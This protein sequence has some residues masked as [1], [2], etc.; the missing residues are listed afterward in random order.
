M[1]KCLIVLVCL[2]TCCGTQVFAGL[3]DGLVAYYPFEGNV[4]DHSSIGNSGIEHNISYPEGVLGKA[5]QFDGGTSYIEVPNSASL[6]P[7]SA[8]TVSAWVNTQHENH[9][10][11][12]VDKMGQ[13]SGPGWRMF[14]WNTPASGFLFSI[15]TEN[16][17]WQENTALNFSTGEWH[18]VLAVY[19]GNNSK[20]YVDGNLK[21][22]LTTTGLIINSDCN[23]FIGCRPDRKYFFDGLIDE[24]R[25][26]D[27]ALTESEVQELYWEGDFP[28]K[29]GLVAHYPFEGDAKDVSGN[30][31][32]GTPSGGVNYVE[33][34]KGQTAYF[35]GIDD[36][37]DLGSNV[38][39]GIRCIS[40]W[41][42]PQEIFDYTSLIT[43]NSFGE[44]GEFTL[45]FINGSVVWGRRVGS[46]PYWV[47]SDPGTWTDGWY[48]IVGNIS[49]ELGMQLYING[50][51]CPSQSQTSTE[52]TDSRSE[53]TSIGRWGDYD[54]RYFKG[55]IDE[56]RIYNRALSEAEIQELY[57][58][59]SEPD[60]NVD[61]VSYDF[62]E[63]E[64][65]SPSTMYVN[66][67]N[68]GGNTLTVND[69]Y[70]LYSISGEPF[71]AEIPSLP[72][73]IAA[74]TSVDIPVSYSPSFLFAAQSNDLIIESDD[75]DE[76]NIEV[77]FT[78]TGVVAAGDPPDAI[79]DILFYIDFAVN[80]GTLV[81]TGDGNSAQAHYEALK[82]ILTSA[83][84]ANNAC[85]PLQAAY[86]RVDGDPKQKD[87][88][89]GPAVE[90]IATAIE[91]VMNELG[92]K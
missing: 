48:H 49:E 20:I 73:K 63:V 1:R 12:I 91:N 26:Y 67:A 64:V 2:L 85:G 15:Y 5:A 78:G 21:E 43:R 92:C 39:N 74:N 83:G 46:I 89:E 76:P 86:K 23:L 57:L 58:I 50:V 75:P 9:T 66:I 10:G 88:A 16:Y 77:A 30:G 51:A 4:A 29:N 37:I 14:T 47:F 7:T 79:G 42:K 28:L 60:I 82:D 87:W 31:N 6:N 72:L 13:I 54:G 53:A 8:I 3:D 36:Y 81:F 55:S 27:R 25:I 41:A 38:G 90:G 44:S 33:G 80:N 65:G 18:H 34:V 69:I 70:F 19:D 71:T 17:T 45:T 22:Q 68:N 56:V 59:G 24:L 61:P 35:D 32:D 40:L 52:P 62:G 84:S 11:R